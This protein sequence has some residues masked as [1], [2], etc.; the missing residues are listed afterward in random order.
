[1][2]SPD[3]ADAI[4][5]RLD[6]VRLARAE[7]LGRLEGITAAEGARRREGEWSLQE[8]V[9]H[10]VLAERAGFDLIWRAAEAYRAGTPVWEGDS[11]NEGLPIEEVIQRTWKARETAPPV[12]TPTGEGS[13][14]QWMAHLESCDALLG[15]LPAQ[16]EGLP[17]RRVIYPHFLSGP[18]D[19]LQ[20]LEFIRFHM[21]H[22]LPQIERIKAEQELG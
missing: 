13:L 7:L 11:E 6:R 12:A 22:H 3:V 2:T 8:V 9:E 17:L 19:A 1:M 21:E 10:L 15:Q 20:R 16:L 5:S 4:V 14:G 18:L